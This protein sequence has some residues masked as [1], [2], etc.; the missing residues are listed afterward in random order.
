MKSS[1]EKLR[2]LA[3]HKSD[4]KERRDHQSLAQLDE[5]AQAT[6]DMQEMRS[7]YDNLLSAAAATANSAYEFSESLLEMGTCLLERTASSV[8]GESGGV[9]QILG[10]AQI[11]LQKIIDTYRSHI[12]LTITNPSESLLSE[13]RKVEEMKLQ[14]DEKREVYEHMLAQYREKGKFRSGKGESITS[15]Q[16]KEARV[17]YDEVARRC[18][19][20]VKSLKQGQCR[21]L[22]TQAA[23]HHTAQLNY[24]RKGLKSLEEVDSQTRLVCEKQRID[25]QVDGLNEGED[26]DSENRSSYE[27][28]EHGELSFDYRNNQGFV[29]DST[30]RIS[31]E[32]DE[33]DSSH[34]HF[35]NSEEAEKIRRKN[36]EG[37]GFGQ[38][39]RPSSYSAPIYPE[40]FNP[41]DKAREVQPSA[42]KSHTYVLPTPAP[43][44]NSSSSTSSSG[45]QSGSAGL[46]TNTTNLRHSSPLRP[47]KHESSN[48][49]SVPLPPPATRRTFAQFEKHNS[50]DLNRN[51]R[52]AYSG[53]IPSKPILSTSGP[54]T[55]KEHPL[56]LLPRVPVSLLSTSP[57]AS[58][59]ASPPPLSSPRISELHELP[60]PPGNIASKTATS[61]G[62]GHSAPLVSRN[63]HSSTNRN[64]KLAP[65]V[66]TP[67][68]A[69]PLTV[70][71]SFS[72][73]SSSLKAQASHMAKLLE[74]SQIPDRVEDFTSPPL[75]PISLSD[76]KPLSTFSEAA[77]NYGQPRGGS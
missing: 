68:P 26:D 38:K 20:R 9:L 69:P 76:M 44:K 12:V 16:V 48:S 64:P 61:S 72:I 63:D 3:L 32:L 71:R 36:P 30:L 60:R 45:P 47:E 49:S 42:Q 24:F 41:A 10:K 43:A 17:E 6:Q 2:K 5:L 75:T 66:A 50:F 31:A 35:F 51:K 56:V 40:K 11:E 65:N 14:C 58:R 77:S 1:L 55:S 4:A 8:Y 33:A 13:L 59:S 23:R 37:H 57:N 22:L 28:N 34:P 18:I 73:P 21:S 25:Y 67:L 52:Q 7:C 39:P 29:N 46:S 15:Q 19:F 70:P 62:I 53:P 74:P 27:N 54:L